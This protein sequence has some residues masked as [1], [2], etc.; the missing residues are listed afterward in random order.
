VQAYVDEAL[1]WLQGE[2]SSDDRIAA[3][4]DD[5]TPAPIAG[6]DG[7]RI[8]LAD[9]NADMRRYVARLLVAAGF[10]V[11]M[12]GDG[13]AALAAA[14]AGVAGKAGPD[15]ILSDVMMPNLDGLGLVAA[16]RADPTLRDVP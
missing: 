6:A 10:A 1:G 7:H 4:G 8:L 12:V 16:L 15:L 5:F 3:A 9:D 2:P 14:R 13:A 11:E